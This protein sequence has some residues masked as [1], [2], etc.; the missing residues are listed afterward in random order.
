MKNKQ[1]RI[2]E[3][4]EI[5]STTSIGSQEELLNIL[6]TR[7]YSVTQATL[8]R[9]LKQIKAVK[10]PISNGFYKYVLPDRSSITK[11]KIG[12]SSGFSTSGFL[13]ISFSG[14]MAVIKTRPGYASSIAYE[15]DANAQEEILGTVAGDDTIFLVIAENVTRKN[16][17]KSLASFIPNIV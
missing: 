7:D 2:K 8:S 13:N 5:I 15:I 16:V 4:K 9:D 3:I 6:V 10:I 17:L 12:E 1:R 14:C 11:E